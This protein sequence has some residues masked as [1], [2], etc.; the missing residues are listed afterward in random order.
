MVRILG[1]VAVAVCGSVILLLGLRDGTWLAG[2]LAGVALAMALIPEEFPLVLTV[3]MVM[4]AWRISRQGVLTRKSS[5]IETLGSATVLCT[6]K[7][8]TLTLNRMSVVTGWREGRFLQDGDATGADDMARLIRIGVLASAAN[9]FDPMERALHDGGGAPAV[10]EGLTARRIYGLTPELLAVTQVWSGPQGGPWL[11]AAK[12]APETIA[13]MCGLSEADRAAVIAAAEDL[14]AKGVRVLGLA[15]GDFAGGEPPKTPRAFDLRFAG[16]IGLADP[17][18]ADVPEAVEAC[19]AAG[20][21]V[22]M[23]TGDLAATALS[24]A[25]QAGLDGAQV[26]TGAQVAALSDED[27]ARRASSVTIF[28]RILP[29]QKLRIV[30]ALQA[31]G[32]VVAMTGDGVNDAPAL[33]AADIGVA[34]GER[35]SDV[36]REAAALVLLKDG[37]AVIVATIRLG[38]RIYDNLR[39]AG[40]FILAVHIPI[41]GLALFPLMTGGGLVL[42]PVH[43]AFL[44]MIID[45]VCS[46]VFEAEPEADDLMRRPPRDPKAPLLTVSRVAFS[47][48]QGGIGLIAVLAVYL[49]DRARGVPPDGIRA[50]AFTALVLV[51][52]ALIFANRASAPTIRAALLR[53]NAWLWSLVCAT[54]ALL[55]AG[56]YIPA[57]RSLLQFGANDA[58]GMAAAVLA[59]LCAGLAFMGMRWFRRSLAGRRP[60]PAQARPSA[61]RRRPS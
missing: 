6:D 51:D 26:M 13:E 4:G 58:P 36:A 37:F 34:M 27:L 54:L 42:G 7:T 32:E 61:P 5:A 23:V 21:R 31:A 30:R 49:F 9:P 1:L 10:A 33:K 38:R 43:I 17:L 41:A 15:E 2:V 29:E 35:G 16:L 52:I 28:A 40:G 12:G 45:P 3:F 47:L 25:A 18:R 59:A 56:L 11:V 24:I 48:A 53:P 60:T 20:M 14:A 46:V 44:E 55:F 19:R 8:G 50:S 57:A 39:N 22:V